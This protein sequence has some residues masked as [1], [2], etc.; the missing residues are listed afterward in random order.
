[1]SFIENTHITDVCRVEYAFQ[2]ET[3]NFGIMNIFFKK[4]QIIL[5][6]IFE[7]ILCF[8]TNFEIS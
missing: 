5:I 6:F 8:H 2:K 4:Q 1:M 3:V 7:I